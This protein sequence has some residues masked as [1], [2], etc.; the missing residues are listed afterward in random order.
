MVSTIV[1]LTY[2]SPRIFAAAIASLQVQ[3]I[4][5]CLN[6]NNAA[7]K[8][9]ADEL[10]KACSNLVTGNMIHLDSDALEN[11]KKMDGIILLAVAGDTE[12]KQIRRDL[13]VCRMQKIPVLGVIVVE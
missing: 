10:V 9:L 1:V 13:D 4:Q 8:G 12:Q 7:A 11:A 6:Q 3:K 2:L 5:L